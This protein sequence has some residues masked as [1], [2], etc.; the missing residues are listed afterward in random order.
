MIINQKIPSTKQTQATTT[1]L[2]GNGLKP[3]KRLFFA[4]Y[5]VER[6]V[7]GQFRIGA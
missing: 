3:L 6:L 4:A 7:I 5:D 2:D 1:A